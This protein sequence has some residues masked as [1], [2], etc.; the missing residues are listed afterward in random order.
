MRRK[1][2]ASPDKWDIAGL[3]KIWSI[4]AFDER[5]TAPHHGFDGAS[6]YYHRASAMR[7]IDRIA[8]P[9]LIVTAEDD[10]FVPPE[11]FRD[12]RV[13]GNPNITTVI[14]SHG[15]HCGFIGQPSDYDG[16]WAEK[17]IVDFVASKM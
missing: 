5:Y 16:Y 6:D 13:A 8:I 3:W 2:K 14:T 17:M 11:P 15:G 9:A 10:P 4:R 1:A 7:V 12:P